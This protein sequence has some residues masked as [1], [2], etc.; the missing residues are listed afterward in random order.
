VS[1]AWRLI[2]GATVILTVTV[3]ALTVASGRMLRNR[4]EAALTDELE[5]DARSIA[6]A[7]RGSPRDPNALAHLY[8]AALGRRVTLIDSAGRVVGDSDFDDPSLR[9]LDNHADR[10]EVIAAKQGRRGVTVRWSES[11]NRPELKVAIAAGPGIVRVS[12]AY[13]DVDAII[14]D[15]QRAMWLIAAAVLVVGAVA[16]V[17]LG[18]SLGR[19]LR[20]L[21]RAASA[22]PAPTGL[23]YPASR[24]PEI[25][26]LVNALRTMQQ[27]LSA[28]IAE[29]SRERDETETLIE[30]MVEGIIGCDAAGTVVAANAATRKLLGYEPGTPLPPVRELFRQRDARTVV[31]Q[32]LTGAAVPEREVDLDGRTILMTAR[33]LPKGGAVFVLHDLT[34][35]RR[36]QAVGRDFVANVSHELKTPLTNIIGYLETLLGH[37]T[38]DP[39]QR[40]LLEVGLNNARRMHRLVDDLLDLARLESGAWKLQ[41]ESVDVTIAAHEAWV[42]F[43]KRAATRGVGF[44]VNV[45]G[46]V[47]RLSADPGALREILDNLFDN[48][49]RY[50][51]DG[52]KICVSAGARGRDIEIAVRDTG[53]GIPAEHLPRI[54]E[55]FYRVDPGRSRTEGGTGLG[56]SIVKHLVEAHSG[57]VEAESALG[58]GTTIRLLFPTA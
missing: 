28:R 50:T 10:P 52:G 18:R 15:A 6:V 2:I 46:A 17:L 1:F 11:T 27:E 44:E 51:Q 43:A 49:L 8:G 16:S 4:V 55:R 36:L 3:T 23:S 42:P 47:S 22:L 24:A 37:G 13:A 29:L 14:R 25:Q 53:T 26:Q 35:L 9:L 33:P 31:E 45:P 32:A 58:R 48:A 21:A 7:I 57:R 54:F 41:R 5:R 19:P 39:E 20:E 38:Q 40:W 30:S 56:L 12:A 34:D